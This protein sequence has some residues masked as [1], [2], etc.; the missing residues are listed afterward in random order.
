MK[1][2]EFVILVAQSPDWYRVSFLV[3]LLQQNHNWYFDGRCCTYWSGSGS[4]IQI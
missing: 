3:F 2:Q 4:F 1:G